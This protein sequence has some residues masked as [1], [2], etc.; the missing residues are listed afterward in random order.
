MEI[1]YTV[2]FVGYVFLAIYSIGLR[3][4]EAQKGRW[5]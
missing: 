1:I 4:Y 3:S 5:E 2:A